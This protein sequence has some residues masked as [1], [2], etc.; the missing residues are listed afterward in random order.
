[1]KG[2]HVF[3]FEKFLFSFLFEL[4]EK[5]SEET[6]SAVQPSMASTRES[7]DQ[8]SDD[9]TIKNLTTLAPGSNRKLTPAFRGKLVTLAILFQ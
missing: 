1:M 8:E 5:E 6:M 4:E 2:L 7:G 9:G 3:P